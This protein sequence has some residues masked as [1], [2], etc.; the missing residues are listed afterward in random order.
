MDVTQTATGVSLQQT[1]LMCVYMCICVWCA[2]SVKFQDIGTHWKALTYKTEKKKKTWQFEVVIVFMRA[3]DKEYPQKLVVHF[4]VG[5]NT[6][7]SPP[8]VLHEHFLI[9]CE[10][11]LRKSQRKNI[12]NAV[13]PLRVTLLLWR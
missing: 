10:D 2:V 6:N 4:E 3:A 9:F 11:F 5:E 1:K 7:F 13:S 8:S 12:C